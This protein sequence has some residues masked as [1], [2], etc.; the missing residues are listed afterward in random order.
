MMKTPHK[1]REKLV[2]QDREINGQP[3]KTPRRDDAEHAEEKEQQIVDRIDAIVVMQ[4]LLDQ[5]IRRNH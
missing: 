2:Q 1:K 5:F 3:E 4:K